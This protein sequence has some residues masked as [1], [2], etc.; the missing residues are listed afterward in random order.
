MNLATGVD[1]HMTADFYG[2]G[3]WSSNGA[4]YG[5]TTALWNVN[6]GTSVPLAIPR[7]AVLI[8]VAPDGTATAE[9]ATTHAWAANNVMITTKT[10][11]VRDASGRIVQEVDARAAPWTI[12]PSMEGFPWPATDGSVSFWYGRHLDWV[13]TEGQWTVTLAD[14]VRPWPPRA[15]STIDNRAR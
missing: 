12:S 6:T 9:M 15:A 7:D 14:A 5:T 8:D 2:W 13:P 1:T 11:R 4:Y 3:G 10:V